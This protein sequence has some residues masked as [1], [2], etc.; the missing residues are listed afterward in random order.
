MKKIIGLALVTVLVLSMGIMVFA[1]SDE[2]ETEVPS[3]YKDMIEW[4]EDQ[5]EKSLEDG[6]ITEDQAKYWNSHFEYMEDFHSQSGFGFPGACH[7][8]SFGRN[9]FRGQGYGP[10]MM[11]GYGHG[12]GW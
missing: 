11:G 5:I 6:N 8:G 3:W 7:G 12:M 4:K 1:E 2:T 10:G 9:S